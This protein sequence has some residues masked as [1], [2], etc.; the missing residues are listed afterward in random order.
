M[1]CL[2]GAAS[3][4]AVASLAIQLVQSINTIREFIRNVKGA[5]EELG[6]LVEMLGR[7][8]ALM[9]D[10]HDIMGRQT[11][12]QSC[13]LPSQTIYNCLK[14]CETNLR[15]LENIIKPHNRRQ[16]VH[17][18]ALIKLKHDIKF[19]FKSKD[20][21]TF[22]ARVQRDIINLNTALGANG[23]NIQ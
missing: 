2:A 19:G 11:L 6:R 5:S 21:A 15:L 16:C 23:T 9:V 14:S 18:P 7:L 10:I 20:I 22:E 4:I 8:N 13:P 12:L 3:G 1:E 17:A